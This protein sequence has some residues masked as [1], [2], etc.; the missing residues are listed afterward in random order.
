MSE[1]MNQEQTETKST[2]ETKPASKF[3]KGIVAGALSTLALAG[4]AFAFIKYGGKVD[5]TMPSLP[6]KDS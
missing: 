1:N 2:V 3:G 4:A 5:I 6:S